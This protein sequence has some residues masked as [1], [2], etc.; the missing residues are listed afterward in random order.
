M[1]NIGICGPAGRQICFTA[2]CA[3]QEAFPQ[4][5]RL[6]KASLHYYKLLP[7][8][9]PEHIDFTRPHRF[10]VRSIVPSLSGNICPTR[11]QKC[12]PD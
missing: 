6:A 10:A 1:P 11:L 3:K 12:M 5:A 7:L 2:G 4:R 9:A 8:F